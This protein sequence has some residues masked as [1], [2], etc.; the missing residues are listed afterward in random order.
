ML[1][2]KICILGGSGFVGRTLAN[3]LTRKGYQLR[4]PTRDRESHRQDLILL[5]T[6]E[7]V[8]ANIHDPAQLREQLTGCDAVINLVGILNERGRDGSDFRKVHV[9]LTQSVIE[10][11]HAIGVRRYLHMSALNADADKGPSYYL[12]TKGQAEQ[13]ALTAESYDLHVTSFRPSVIFG[14]DDSF[15][16]RFAKLLKFTPLMFPLACPKARFAP[17]YV[18]DVAE[19]FAQALNDPQTYGHAYDLCGPQ[20]YTLQ[21]LVEYTARCAGLKRKIL[22]LGDFLSRLQAMIFDFVPGKPFSTDNYLSTRVDNVCANDGDLKRFG[23]KPTAIEALVP[24]YLSNRSA[25]SLYY[26]YRRDAGRQE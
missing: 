18:E 20:E 1:I 17:V 7:L 22:P 13:Q 5:P 19:A 16:N 21:Q 14:P 9:D 8:E 26:A 4:I 10:T 11:C 23:I 15:F 6:T 12:K 2:K 24:R 3:Q 25:R